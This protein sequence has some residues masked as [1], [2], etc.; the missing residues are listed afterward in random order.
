MNK[1]QMYK[2]LIKDYKLSGR[3]ANIQKVKQR[4]A[5]QNIRECKARVFPK[6][7]AIRKLAPSNKYTNCSFQPITSC[8]ERFF[9]FRPLPYALL[10]FFLPPMM[11]GELTPNPKVESP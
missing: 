4:Q 8:L 11:V 7:R 5:K 6:I 2:I 9:F 3:D 10:F 1:I